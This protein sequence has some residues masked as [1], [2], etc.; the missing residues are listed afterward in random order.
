[1]EGG[2][3]PCLAMNHADHYCAEIWN[4][5][6]GRANT[7][8]L[9]EGGAVYVN[10]DGTFIASHV[11]IRENGADV[12]GAQLF[13]T[14]DG[15]TTLSNVLV[16]DADTLNWLSTD[17]VVVTGSATL[18]ATAS[19][20]AG[21]AT[22]VDYGASTFGV[23]EGNVVW[24]DGGSGAGVLASGSVAGDCNVGLGV[25]GVVGAA[26]L[27]VDPLFTTTARG[28]YRLG[29]GSPALQNCGSASMPDDDLD[30]CTR[31]TP[32]TDPDAGAFERVASCP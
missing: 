26:N 10:T 15:I 13:L 17:G 22:T 30:F 7:T 31:L 8:T 5:Q 25:S 12:D 20:F 16:A 2:N 4:N 9:G 23:F 19:T 14:G 29:S 1:M 24:P 21:E 18:H 28:D 27:T 3:P 6:A 32:G 11:G